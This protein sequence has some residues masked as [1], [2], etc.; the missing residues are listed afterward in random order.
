MELST[1]GKA[2]GELSAMAN[3]CLNEKS[4]SGHIQNAVNVMFFPLGHL[5]FWLLFR[6]YLPVSDASL[7]ASDLEFL[8]EKMGFSVKH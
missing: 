6:I 7:L 2:K 8:T 3:Q 1:I 5:Y 4:C